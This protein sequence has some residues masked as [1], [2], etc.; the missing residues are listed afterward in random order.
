MQR[1]LKYSWKTPSWTEQAIQAIEELSSDDRPFTPVDIA[2][3]IAGKPH[4]QWA[5]TRSGHW[6]MA[7]KRLRSIIAQLVDDGTI[8]NVGNHTRPKFRKKSH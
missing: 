4:G 7:N 2:V 6:D 3:T 8:E 1:G 5:I